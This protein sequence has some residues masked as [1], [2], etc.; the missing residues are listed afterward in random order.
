M[1]GFATADIVELCMANRASL[2]FLVPAILVVMLLTI[3]GLV[4]FLWERK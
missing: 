1:N 4:I 3:L 2:D